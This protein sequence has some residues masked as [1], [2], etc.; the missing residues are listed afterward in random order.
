MNISFCQTSMDL[1]LM[2]SKAV[3]GPRFP[4]TSWQISLT[5]FCGLISLSLKG[6]WL[7]H[8]GSFLGFACLAVWKASPFLGKKEVQM[9]ALLSFPNKHG[10][11]WPPRVPRAAV[12]NSRSKLAL[13][14]ECLLRTRWGQIFSRKGKEKTVHMALCGPFVWKT[15]N[16][17][18][19]LVQ[20]LATF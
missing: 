19:R 10:C 2:V 3:C 6:P 12:A 14:W 16:L 11:I 4:M 5:L 1:L 15:G 13:S 20:K 9:F 18:R 8:H 17:L 7:Q